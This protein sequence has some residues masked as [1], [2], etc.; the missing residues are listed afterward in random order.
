MNDCEGE[1]TDSVSAELLLQLSS[2]LQGRVRL[3]CEE[4]RAQSEQLLEAVDQLLI[5]P[6]QR[7]TAPQL[8]AAGA[9]ST[10]S[11][12]QLTLHMGGTV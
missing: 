10:Q 1:L 2:A 3:L 9:D 5:L 4:L 7:R 6:L 12:V 11:C 8:L